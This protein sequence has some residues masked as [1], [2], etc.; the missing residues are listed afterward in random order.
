MTKLNNLLPDDHYITTS[1]AATE[2]FFGDS[3]TN[4]NHVF[5]YWGVKKVDSTGISKWDALNV[6]KVVWNTDF[7]PYPVES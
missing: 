4:E 7:D 5:M 3:G 2:K 6:G 1:T